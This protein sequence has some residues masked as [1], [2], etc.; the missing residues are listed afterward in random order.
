MNIPSN[1]LKDLIATLQ[2]L[3]S[4]A[5]HHYVSSKI[6]E[7]RNGRR[8]VNFECCSNYLIDINKLLDDLYDVLPKDDL[9]IVEDVTTIE[10]FKAALIK[11]LSS[12]HE[13]IKELEDRLAD[14][15]RT[16]K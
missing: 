3:D 14:L 15:Q 1:K 9:Q 12:L 16:T 5:N 11:H 6:F 7:T 4:D 8:F 13:R 10:E 2:T